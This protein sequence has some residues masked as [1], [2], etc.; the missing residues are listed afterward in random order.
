M[1]GFII[2]GSTT[3]GPETIQNMLAWGG[4]E[5]FNL[6]LRRR[7]TW[8]T[9]IQAN[10]SNKD[11]KNDEA[12]EDEDIPDVKAEDHKAGESSPSSLAGTF[13]PINHDRSISSCEETGEADYDG[14][15]E[16][17]GAKSLMC[18]TPTE[19]ITTTTTTTTTTDRKK[20]RSPTIIPRPVPGWLHTRVGP[21]KT[22]NE[23]LSTLHDLRA[24]LAEIVHQEQIPHF[25]DIEILP[26]L[27]PL[28]ATPSRTVRAAARPTLQP[29]IPFIDAPTPLTGPIISS[30]TQTLPR[31]RATSLTLHRPSFPSETAV[32]GAKNT[33]EASAGHTRVRRDTYPSIAL[34]A[35]DSD[36]T[37]M[38]TEVN[39]N[40]A[41]NTS[42]EFAIRRAVRLTNASR[43]VSRVSEHGAVNKTTK[44]K[45][46]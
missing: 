24:H 11:D 2:A 22:F 14:N 21:Y 45:K 37:D 31:R 38:A 28:A 23:I 9:T 40:D 8:R 3:N 17:H 33:L 12:D 18:N 32:L 36:A 10:E 35:E 19:D 20:K 46:K 43:R 34:P 13:T 1:Y 29:L 4:V 41:S 15:E 25:P 26:N 44:K 7:E 30:P 42:L 16:Q 39:D 27:C 6:Q 5:S